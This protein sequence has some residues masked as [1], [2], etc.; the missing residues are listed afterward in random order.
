MMV[1]QPVY[2]TEDWLD[3]SHFSKSKPPLPCIC[4][5]FVPRQ[6]SY[7]FST[8]NY[9]VKHFIAKCEVSI[10][11]NLELLC[12][13]TSYITSVV[14]PSVLFCFLVNLRFFRAFSWFKFLFS[15][16]AS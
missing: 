4:S 14:R 15:G 11:K 1:Y 16:Y 6:N 10:F 5:F 8:K 2:L 13:N 7:Q 3:S 9:L 12:R